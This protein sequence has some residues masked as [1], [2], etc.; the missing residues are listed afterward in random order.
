MWNVAAQQLSGLRKGKNRKDS[1]VPGEEIEIPMKWQ[2]KKLN[3][4]SQAPE[5]QVWRLRFLD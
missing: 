4:R 2:P 5:F 3:E 1:L